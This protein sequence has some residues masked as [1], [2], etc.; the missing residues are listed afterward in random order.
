[1]NIPPLILMIFVG[2]LVAAGVYLTLERSLSRIF[3]GLSLMTNGI[4]L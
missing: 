2:V 1:M 3:I 4:N